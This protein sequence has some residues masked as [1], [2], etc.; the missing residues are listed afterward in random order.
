MAMYMRPAPTGDRYATVRLA[1]AALGAITLTVAA[2]LL[3]GV[4]PGAML[5]LA[6]QTGTTLTQT[7]VPIAGP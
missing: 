1:P 6:G 4:W 3:F 5:D 2:V 7:G